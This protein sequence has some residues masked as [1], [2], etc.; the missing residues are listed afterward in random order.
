[1]A[2]GKPIIRQVTWLSMLP[3]LFIMGLL[4]LGFALLIERFLTAL[5]VAMITYVTISNLLERGIPHNHR[6][7]IS[8]SNKGDYYQAIEEYKKSYDFFSRHSWIDKYRYITLLS[9]S[10]KSYTEMS[11]INIAYCYVQI[12]DREQTKQYYE[13]ALALFPDNEMAKRALNIISTLEN[14]S[15]DSAN[16]IDSDKH[17]L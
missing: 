14:E 15:S 13:K 17:E 5:I 11:L 1:M 16:S 8:L 3:Q 12:G 7:G 4:V 9:S 2:P 6:K 10:K